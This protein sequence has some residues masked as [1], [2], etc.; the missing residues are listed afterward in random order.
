MFQ[1]AVKL[2]FNERKY[3]NIGIV[4]LLRSEN[5]VVSTFGKRFGI[6]AG[7]ML[8][9]AFIRWYRKGPDHK[10]VYT[11]YRKGLTQLKNYPYHKALAKGEVYGAQEGVKGRFTFP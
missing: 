5:Y 1:R 10:P 11:P 8:L 9:P 7:F 6:F 3:M 4:R 2:K